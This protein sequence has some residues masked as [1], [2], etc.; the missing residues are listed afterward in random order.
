[1]LALFRAGAGVEHGV[2]NM[3]ILGGG[4]NKGHGWRNCVTG[5]V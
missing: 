5:K 1:M 4:R 3:G 2:R